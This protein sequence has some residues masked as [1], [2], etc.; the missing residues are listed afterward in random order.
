[1]Q[2]IRLDAAAAANAEDAEVWRWFSGLLEERRVRWRYMFSRWVVNVDRVHVAT[3]QNF[4]DAIRMA[5]E[6][7]TRRGLGLSTIGCSRIR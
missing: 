7:A 1:M 5:K 3:E 6:V 2:R 4:Y